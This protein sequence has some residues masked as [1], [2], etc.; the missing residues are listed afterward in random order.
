[1]VEGDAGG[2]DGVLNVRRD[3][4]GVAVAGDGGR[5]VEVGGDESGGNVLSDGVRVE[6]I[7]NLT[8]FNVPPNRYLRRRECI[9]HSG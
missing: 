6:V 7:R 9:F 5:A 3:A 8:V 4:I 1:M 2:R